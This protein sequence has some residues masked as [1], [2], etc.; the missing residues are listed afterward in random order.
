MTTARIFLLLMISAAIVAGLRAVVRLGANP[1][2]EC[3][4]D[5]YL[6]MGNRR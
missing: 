3:L 4:T 5:R 6:L 1:R 2:D